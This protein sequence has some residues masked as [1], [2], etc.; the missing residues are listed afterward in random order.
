MRKPLFEAVRGLGRRRTRSFVTLLASQL[1][2]TI[3]SA[4]I[5]RDFLTGSLDLESA[6]GAMI[7][8][9]HQGDAI[10]GRL[11]HLLAEAI[12]TPLDREDLFRLSR[13]I[14]DALD[15]LRDFLREWDLYGISGSGDLPSVLDAVTDAARRLQSAV[16]MLAA[17]PTQVRERALRAKKACNRIRRLYQEEM[18]ALFRE[19]VSIDLLKRREL[20]R[21]LDLVGLRL[22]EAADVLSDAALKRGD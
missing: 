9:E 2:A 8:T 20:L 11:V 4:Q 12:V 21:R 6:R 13:S 10:R 3:A 19:D 1:D 17:A 22:D 16:A 14:D 5:V 18:A 15:G 7:T